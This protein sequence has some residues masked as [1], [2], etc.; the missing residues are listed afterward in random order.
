MDSNDQNNSN[1]ANPTSPTSPA[2]SPDKL[3]YEALLSSIGEGLIVM[4]NE[5]NIITFNKAAE[6]ML[7]WSSAEAVGKPLQDI[8]RMQYRGGDNKEATGS[9]DKTS[10]MLTQVAVGDYS[11]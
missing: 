7:G 9:L 10:K 8:L 11:L 1:P 5:G 6:K 4:N 3:K 2:D